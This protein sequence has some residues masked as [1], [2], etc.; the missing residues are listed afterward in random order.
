[1]GRGME[2]ALW[3]TPYLSIITEP[4]AFRVLFQKYS[5]PTSCPSKG[6]FS[7]VPLGWFLRAPTNSFHVELGINSRQFT[8]FVSAKL[9]PQGLFPS[10]GLKASK[11]SWGVE[12]PESLPPHSLVSITNWKWNFFSKYSVEWRF[13]WVTLTGFLLE[14][15]IPHCAPGH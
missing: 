4:V 11:V 9:E 1:M 6:E 7:S 13:L 14:T 12:T 5:P 10:M 8:T 2:R 15:G 3:Q